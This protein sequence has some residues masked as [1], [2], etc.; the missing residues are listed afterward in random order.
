[1]S[2]E[3]K[4][5]PFCG[6]VPNSSTERVGHSTW[7]TFVKCETCAF[8]MQMSKWNTR[9]IEDALR[10][11]LEA[12]REAADVLLRHVEIVTPESARPM[13]TTYR[14]ALAVRKA[15]ESK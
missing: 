13:S 6:G 10:T 15:L 2:D 11:E 1:M 8:D 7:L 3:L 12:A 4:P 14:L 5:C 9:P